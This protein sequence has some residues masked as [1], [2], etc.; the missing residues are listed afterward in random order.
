MIFS[1]IHSESV[2][3]STT[4][5]V[6]WKLWSMVGCL[7]AVDVLFV[8]IWQIVDPLKK[9]ITAFDTIPSDNLDEDVEYQPEIWVCR[10]DYHNVWLGRSMSAWDFRKI[11]CI[12]HRLDL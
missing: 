4:Q 7:V 9:K 11:F 8:T 3:I 5:V 12:C 10:S 6:P 1:Y 2:Y